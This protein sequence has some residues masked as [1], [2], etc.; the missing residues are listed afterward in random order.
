MFKQVLIANRG[1]IACRIAR[2]CRRL[3][4]APVGVHSSADLDALHPS[5]MD[6]SIGLGGAS[7]T[8][9]YL[10]IDAVIDAAR[11]TG[12]EAIHPGYGFLAENPAFAEAVEAAGLVFI[13]PTPDTLRRLGH[14][15]Q[16]K[17]EARAAGVPVLGGG[18]DA[19]ADAETVAERAR[20]VTLPVLLKPASGGGGKGMHVVRQASAYCT[21][22]TAPAI[23]SRRRAA[24]WCWIARWAWSQY[25]QWACV[26]CRRWS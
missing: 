12:A 18:E 9:S 13:G 7:A 17:A 25:C 22:R 15:G 4:I 2:T 3:G 8:E 19:S 23:N 1:E 14:K 21:P 6:T 16:A 5:V 20:S 26:R 11:R 10:R 24:C